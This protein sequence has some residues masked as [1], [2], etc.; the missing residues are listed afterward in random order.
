VEKVLETATDLELTDDELAQV[1]G[2]L[3]QEA[4]CVEEPII[5]EPVMM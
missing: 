5:A 2:G 4:A 3:D 1:F